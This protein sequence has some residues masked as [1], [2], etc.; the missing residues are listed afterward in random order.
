MIHNLSAS[1]L[2][3]LL[4]LN[5]PYGSIHLINHNNIFVC[6]KFVVYFSYKRPSSFNLSIFLF[7]SSVGGW[8]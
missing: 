6:S 7:C 2:D 8:T 4:P 5:S 1:I 3:T